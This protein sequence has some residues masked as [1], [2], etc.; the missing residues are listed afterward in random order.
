MTFKIGRAKNGEIIEVPY[1][2]QAKLIILLSQ[3]GYHKYIRVPHYEKDAREVLINY[4]EFLQKRKRKLKE[5]VADRTT[6]EERQEKIMAALLKLLP[7]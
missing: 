5:L 7:R 2:A 3:Q 6:N 1:E 4:G